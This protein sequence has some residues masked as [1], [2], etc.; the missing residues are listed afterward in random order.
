[1][2]D[3]GRDATTAAHTETAATL[4]DTLVV[5]AV[6]VPD[7]IRRALDGDEAGLLGRRL[8]RALTTLVLGALLI[9]GIAWA[10]GVIPSPL[11]FL[12]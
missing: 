9:G 10:G 3:N 4:G 6:G 2:S 5:D 1:M 11:T 7:H 8:L 12:P